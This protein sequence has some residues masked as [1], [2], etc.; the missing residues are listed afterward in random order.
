MSLV[1][2]IQ[3]RGFPSAVAQAWVSVVIAG[4]RLTQQAEQLFAEHGITGDQFNVLRILRGADPGGLARGEITQRLMRRAPDTTRM[5]DRLERAGLIRR[6]RGT[7]D[8][9]R[10]IARITGDGLALLERLDPQV[11]QVMATAMAPLDEAQLREL[12]RLCA[13]LV[14]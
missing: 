9:R 14:P 6:V 4:D 2:R 10:S 8:A 1:E 12:A 13:A 7:D 11:E 3:S 5:L